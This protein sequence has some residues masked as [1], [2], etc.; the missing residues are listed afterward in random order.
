M[1]FFLEQKQVSDVV[2]AVADIPKYTRIQP[3]M[4]TM[5]RVPL[6]SVQPGTLD[7]LDAVVGKIS[8]IAILKG[9]HVSSTKLTIDA[10]E[11]SLA[12]TIPEGKRAMTFQVDRVTLLEGMINPGDKVDVIGT[13]PFSQTVGDMTV[14]QT[15]LVPMFEH[16]LVL[17]VGERRSLLEEQKG[18]PSTITIALAPD[19][20]ALLTFALQMGRI[21][22]FL[23]S[24]LERETS[25]RREPVTV[26]RLWEK[27]LSIRKMEV[28]QKV[29][30]PP[31][32][33]LYI[34]GKKSL[35]QQE[36]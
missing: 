17:A 20:A 35:L 12:L 23:R 34:G 18:A 6:A 4:V 21:T 36:Q 26:D 28:P 31:A 16:V 5:K 22:L 30:E 32:V 13:F 25:V 14:K 3:N 2:V 9:E 33:E 10:P 8:S 7:S 19:E 11:R 24:P 15:V 27:L 29:E 1:A